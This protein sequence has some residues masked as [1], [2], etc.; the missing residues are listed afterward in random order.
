MSSSSTHRLTAAL[1]AF[2]ATA[3]AANDARIR[4]LPHPVLAGGL[5]SVLTN[6]PDWIEPATNPHHRQFFH[7]IIFAGGIAYGMKRAYQWIPQDDGERFMRHLLLIAGGAYLT[8]LALDATTRRSL[9][10]IGK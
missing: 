2:V 9:P 4:D 8:H 6:L 5:A 7:S 3:V 10:F 1:V